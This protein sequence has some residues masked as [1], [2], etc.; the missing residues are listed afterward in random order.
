MGFE[1][2]IE[3]VKIKCTYARAEITEPPEAGSKYKKGEY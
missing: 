3:G 1:R 2:T